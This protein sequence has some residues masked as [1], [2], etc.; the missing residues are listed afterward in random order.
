MKIVF[1]AIFVFFAMVFAG[2]VPDSNLGNLDNDLIDVTP[3]GTASTKDVLGDFRKGP[4]QRQCANDGNCCKKDQCYNRV[5]LGPHLGPREVA[6]AF[7]EYRATKPE[8]IPD[9][10]ETD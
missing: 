1:F 7:H 6:S 3:V 2:A 5:C 10:T 8:P 4:C 9:Q